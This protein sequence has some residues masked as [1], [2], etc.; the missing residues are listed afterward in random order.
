MGVRF[1]VEP[2]SGPK[3][4]RSMT[5]AADMA[6]RN[7][8][9]GVLGA[10]VARSITSASGSGRT[11]DRPIDAARFVVNMLTVHELDLLAKLAVTFAGPQV[12]DLL[13]PGDG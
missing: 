10:K 13:E 8:L 7:E 3:R 12:L 9:I 11:I 1:L 2:A 5:G 4:G 6:T